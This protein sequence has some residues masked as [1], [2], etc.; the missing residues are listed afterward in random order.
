MKD[1]VYP[2][3]TTPVVNDRYVAQ[4]KCCV[5]QIADSS[6]ESD[7]AHDECGPKGIEKHHFKISN[8]LIFV[9]RG[10]ETLFFPWKKGAWFR[11]DI[12][13]TKCFSGPMAAGI[14]ITTRGVSDQVI[15]M[16]DRGTTG[17]TSDSNSRRAM[18]CYYD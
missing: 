9:V 18:F 13:Y 12:W 2:M 6:G 10:K 15:V 8:S 5:S 1:T 16:T 3:E 4:P 7:T 14:P 11:T 17:S